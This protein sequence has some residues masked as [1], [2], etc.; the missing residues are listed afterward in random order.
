M[1]GHHEGFYKE[2]ERR[3]KSVKKQRKNP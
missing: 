1:V 3:A 2:A